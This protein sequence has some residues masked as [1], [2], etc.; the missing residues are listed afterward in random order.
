LF[1]ENFEK[2]SHA[3][4]ADLKNKMDMLNGP[5][6]DMKSTLKTI[7]ISRDNLEQARTD[8][9]LKT[10]QTCLVHLSL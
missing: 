1:R 3:V 4:F 6:V 9:T 10:I 8:I 2:F 7:Q 5:E